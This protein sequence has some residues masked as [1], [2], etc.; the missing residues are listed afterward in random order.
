MNLFCISGE[1][2]ISSN[3]SIAGI[4]NL[5]VRVSDLCGMYTDTTL[6]IFVKETPDHGVL[7]QQQVNI[8]LFD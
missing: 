8:K 6:D 4:Y 5:A 1:I 7:L 3:L 2:H